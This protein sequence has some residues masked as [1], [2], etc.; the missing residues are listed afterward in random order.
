M[1]HRNLYSVAC[2]VPKALIGKKSA[3][4]G[5]DEK[6]V[7]REDELLRE[8]CKLEEGII[9]FNLAGFIWPWRARHSVLYTC[10]REALRIL[11]FSWTDVLACNSVFF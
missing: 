9:K 7:S 5:S 10:S 3:M 1:K 4:P 6:E 8:H 11:F 2:W